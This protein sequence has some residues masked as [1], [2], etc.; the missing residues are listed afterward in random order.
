MVDTTQGPTDPFTIEL[1]KGMDESVDNLNLCLIGKIMVPKL[2]NKQANE[3]DK[4]LV[5]K[6]APWSI[7]GNLLVHGLPMD[8]MTR[9]NGQIIGESIRKTIGVEAPNDGLPLFRSFLIIRVKVNVTL[10]LLRRFKLQRQIKGLT[11]IKEIWVSFKYERLAD[12]CY[13]CGRIGHDK[14]S[15]KFVSREIG[16]QSGYGP[17][18][19][20]GVARNISLP[21]E[22][23]WHQI[24]E[25]EDRL[26]LLLQR[27]SNP[28]RGS[29]DGLRAKPKISQTSTMG[30]G[31]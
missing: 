22:F 14:D 27:N 9:R 12:F 2:L 3:D 18:M 30:N 24:D 28:Q 23:Y 25:L 1:E 20:T 31:A 19:R 26:H 4:A 17:E 29:V 15:C 21:V 8:K 16:R 7:M 5:L 11:E 10:P 13:N 6:T